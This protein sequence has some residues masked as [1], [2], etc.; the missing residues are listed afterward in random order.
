MDK[1]EIFKVLSE[2]PVFHLATCDNV[3]PR[4]RGMLLFKAD[5]SGIVFSTGPGKDMYSQIMKNPKA[6]MCF[7]DTKN[8]VQIRVSGVLEEIKDRKYKE[9]MVNHP[10]RA[11]MKEWK[12]NFSNED[13]FYANV[14]VFVLKQAKAVVW[15]FADNFKPKKEIEL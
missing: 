4:V 1:K 2:N 12:K 11:F 10:S 15:T 8:N 7:Q 3:Q 9:A 6:E 14:T 13:D 5:E